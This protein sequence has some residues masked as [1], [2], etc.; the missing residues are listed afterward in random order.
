[1]RIVGPNSPG[2]VVD[3]ASVGTR[4]WTNPT[5]AQ[6][7]DGLFAD[8]TLPHG[9]ISHYLKAT[10]FGLWLPPDV[11]VLGILV[12]IQHQGFGLVQDYRLRTV[13]GGAIG[14]T[15]RALAVNWITG[16]EAYVG[17]G[18]DSDLWGET[19]TP[20]DFADPTFGVALSA[21]SVA[22]SG[23]QHAFVDHMRITVF[24]T[25]V[26]TAPLRHRATVTLADGTVTGQVTA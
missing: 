12:E 13:K 19:W 15:E 25:G 24:H 23:N 7:S 20:A 11:T 22:G 16:Y 17:Y 3:D 1:M 21:I 14:A 8:P 2:T 26:P 9:T 5:Y 18:G 10:N 4:T 6:V